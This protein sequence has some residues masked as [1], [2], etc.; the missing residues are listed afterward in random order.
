MQSTATRLIF[1][2]EY[3]FAL[4]RDRLSNKD[5]VIQTPCIVLVPF[6]AEITWVR[7][8]PKRPSV[9]ARRG[10]SEHIFLQHVLFQYTGSVG[11]EGLAG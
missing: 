5:G 8:W 3:E 9:L 6:I 7:A 2:A 4:P 1:L 11:D 10:V